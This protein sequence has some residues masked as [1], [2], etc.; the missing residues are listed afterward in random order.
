MGTK[1]LVDSQK[2]TW[3]TSK[4]TK[5]NLLW[6]TPKTQNRPEILSV[7][8]CKNQPEINRDGQMKLLKTSF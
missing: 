5:K 1:K 8:W 6:K 4:T 7:K 2:M 3:T